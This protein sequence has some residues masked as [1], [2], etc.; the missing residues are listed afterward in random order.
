LEQNVREFKRAERDAL[1]STLQLT[2]EE[3]ERAGAMVVGRFEDGTPVTLQK[4]PGTDDPVLNNFNYKDDAAGSRCP[5]HAHV[6][7]VNPRTS[8]SAAGD[9]PFD[10]GSERSRR[11][12]RRGITYGH[13]TR[14]SLETDEL[15]Q[16][17]SGEVGL[18]FMCCQASLANQF[19]FM[20]GAWANNADFPPGQ[21]VAGQPPVGV[22]PV[23]GQ[24]TGNPP[25]PPTAPRVPQQWPTEWGEEDFQKRPKAQF[26]F[27]GFVRM[28]GG[29]Y[30]FVPSLPF[31]TEIVNPPAPLD[32]PPLPGQPVY[33]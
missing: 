14:E 10:P 17:P 6:R 31:L 28:L 18:L 9:L 1:A 8:P 12:T 29:E 3:A 23:I 22:D 2:G 7:K 4:G 26:A 27:G 15:D 33:P 11:I 20:Q 16:L 13:R 5:F 21:P 24:E 25:A 30:F 19:E 32:P